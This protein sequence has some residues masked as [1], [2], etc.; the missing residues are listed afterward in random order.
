M[1]ILI[2]GDCLTVMNQLPDSS[3]DMILCDLPYG[4]TQNKW[5]VVIPM[6]QLWGH[7][8]RLCRGAIVLTASQPF[9]SQLIVSN[10]GQFRYEWIWSKNKS[11]G[12]LNA[13]KRPMLSHESIVVFSENSPVYFPQKTVGHRPSNYAKR[14]TATENYGKQVSTVYEGGSTD[15]Y[16]VSVLN[17]NVVNNDSPDRYH[18]TQKPAELLEYL[19]R[20]YTTEG[21][22][23]LDNC[24]GSG[25]TGVAC[26]NTGRNFI[27][28]E[29]DAEYFEIAR[30]RINA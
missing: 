6:D 18:P 12:H 15:R 9:T 30:K 2:S 1:N 13:K 16:P 28:I 11:S 8:R 3:V 22:W 7:Y 26:A 23:V 21:Q 10:I 17:F 4:T 20:T 29:K 14:T 24:M 25:S 27:G 5:D 19:I